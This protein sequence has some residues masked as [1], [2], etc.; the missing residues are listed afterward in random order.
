MKVAFLVLLATAVV[1][2]DMYLHNPRYV[3][4]V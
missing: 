3:A 1:N 4:L 2:A